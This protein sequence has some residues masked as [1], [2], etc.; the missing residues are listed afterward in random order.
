MQPDFFVHSGD[1][2]YADNPVAAEK[3]L[4]DGKVWKNIVTEAKS[5]VA[6]TLDG[7]RGNYRYN[8][9]DENLRRFN[10][11]V[12]MLAQWDDHDVLRSEER[13]VGKEWR[14]RRERDDEKKDG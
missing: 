8:L 3:K 14:C 5:K 12:P 11:E 2:I 10:A 7:Y 1:T 4:P 9:L 13:R 6:E